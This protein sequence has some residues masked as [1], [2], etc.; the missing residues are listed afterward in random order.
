MGDESKADLSVPEGV[1]LSVVDSVPVI[2]IGEQKYC[3]EGRTSIP[4]TRS[5]AEE[6]RWCVS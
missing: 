6:V 3:S 2:E 5:V 4:G 1:W